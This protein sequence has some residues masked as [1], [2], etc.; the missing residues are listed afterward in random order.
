MCPHMLPDQ[1]CPAFPTSYK[2]VKKAQTCLSFK[3]AKFVLLACP[4]KP[5]L[6]HDSFMRTF[7]SSC[8]MKGGD[9]LTTGLTGSKESQVTQTHLRVTYQVCSFQQQRINEETSS[10]ALSDL[11]RVIGTLSK[12]F[13]LWT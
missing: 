13:R 8:W 4:G 2:T 10:G 6:G 1:L 5:V 9:T 3:D 11:P 7:L 12:E